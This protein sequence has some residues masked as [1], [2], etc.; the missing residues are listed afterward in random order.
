M[1]LQLKL[2]QS[3]GGKIMSVLA[4]A[5]IKM[6]IMQRITEQTAFKVLIIQKRREQTPYRVRKMNSKGNMMQR[7]REQTPYK[8]SWIA[9]KNIVMTIKTFSN[10]RRS[11]GRS[12]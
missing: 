1:L 9:R 6:N 7:K 5:L 2:V 11:N 12:I 10:K 4:L 8:V 3:R